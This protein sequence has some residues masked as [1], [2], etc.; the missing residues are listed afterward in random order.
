M[1][2]DVSGGYDPELDFLLPARPEDPQM[3]DS[4]SM[5]ISDDEGRFGFPRFCIEAVGAHWDNRGVEANIA[6]PDG[7]VLI[8]SGGFAPVPAK[9]VNGKAVTLN[10]GPLTF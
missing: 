8:G 9:F 5:W 2:I 4:V 1:P 3:R 10:A 7:R 6:F